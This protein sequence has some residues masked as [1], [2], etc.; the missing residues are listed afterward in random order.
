MRASKGKR[1]QDFSRN[2]IELEDLR[3][4]TE[5]IG[6]EIENKEEKIEDLVS[7]YWVLDL[8]LWN[9]IK[10]IKI[11]PVL[12]GIIDSYLDK[13]QNRESYNTL[14]SIISL[15]VTS[16]YGEQKKIFYCNLLKDMVRCHYN[17]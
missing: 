1:T 16:L 12:L 2:W 15:D 11:E 4:E 7:R 17:T 9:A 13:G 8:Q 10:E 3:S 14:Q 6:L 5:M